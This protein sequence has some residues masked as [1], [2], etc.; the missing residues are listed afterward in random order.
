MERARREGRRESTG[1]STCRCKHGLAA[2]ARADQWPS[3][4]LSVTRSRRGGP[5]GASGI[6][7]DE[8]EEMIL[9]LQGAVHGRRGGRATAAMAAMSGRWRLEMEGDGGRWREMERDGFGCSWHGEL[10]ARA[11]AG[12]G[13]G[14]ING[15]TGAWISHSA[16]GR[17][18]D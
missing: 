5:S 3:E 17:A 16:G 6:C 7:D 15:A 1:K 10:T 8:N 18:C 14:W 13:D 4:R 12:A 2:A 11:G 9:R